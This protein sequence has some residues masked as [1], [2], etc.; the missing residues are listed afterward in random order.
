MIEID[1]PSYAEDFEITLD[2]F[3]DTRIR[4]HPRMDILFVLSGVL[5]ITT[6]R[7]KAV[8][9]TNH[10]CVVNSMEL[11][12]TFA[13]N[14]CYVVTFS[15]SSHL[16][17]N[18]KNRI[19]CMSGDK[20]IPDEIYHQ[21]RGKLARIFQLY[22][23]DAE[24]NRMQIY[25]RLFAM[26]DIL[27]KYFSVHDEGV[28]HADSSLSQMEQILTYIQENSGWK[29]TLNDLANQFYLSTG[30][31]SR[32][33]TRHLQTTFVDYLR[34]LR[35]TNAYRLLHDEEKSLA[36]IAME[37][38]FGSVNQ[39]IDGFK[40]Y[41]GAT[42]GKLR[43]L[44]YE[45]QPL[46]IDAQKEI[47]D[48]LLSYAEKEAEVVP[49]LSLDAH[50]V[51]RF[52]YR[53]ENTCEGK[54]YTPGFFK[55]I[56]VGFAKDILYAP[57]QKQLKLCQDELGF[58]YIRFH[59]IFDDDMMIYSEDEK[60]RPKYN[61]NYLD[62]VYDYVVSLGFKIFVEFSYYPSELAQ[63]EKPVYHRRSYI[64]GLPKSMKKWCDLVKATVRH[65]IDR[66]GLSTV[67]EWWFR[68]GEGINVYFRRMAFEEYME[69][70]SSTYR[71]VKEVDESLQFGGLNLDFGQL[72]VTDQQDLDKY[73]AGLAGHGC[74]PDFFSFQCF[75]NVYSPDYESS[76]ISALSHRTEPF[77]LSPDEDYMANNLK[78]I[79]KKLRA[80][81][82]KNRPVILDTWNATMW[83][84]DPRNDICFKAAFLFKNMLENA[85]TLQGFGYWVLSDMFEEVHAS[86]QLFHGG[87]GL[88][89]YNGIPKAGYYAFWLLKKL[90][91]Y[92]VQRGDGYYV[93]RKKDGSIQIAMYNYCHY[94][95]FSRQ[96]VFIE[97][98]K[99]N[100]YEMFKN[101]ISR[102]YHL[103]L[104]VTSRNY[105]A[106]RYSVS[107]SKGGSSYEVW[108]DMGS[109]RT[110]EPEQAEYLRQRSL[111][112]YHT[113]FYQAENGVITVS[114]ELE[115]HEICVVILTPIFN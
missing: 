71:A 12:H 26:L 22:Y 68:A 32:L 105:R 93:T 49:G 55:L 74:H 39:M 43:K 92:F 69:L 87:Y 31:I 103:E 30:H 83:Q 42:P 25:S 51:E 88:L 21:I 75:H 56:N 2:D 101:E 77:A 52:Y 84:R 100:R 11:Y 23:K 4:N 109:P 38:G 111:P 24:N 41:Y 16:L 81:D 110:L 29:L 91:N 96:N 70:F 15:I 27:Q 97:G 73:L 112:S 57:I 115:A 36:D 80:Y 13:E 102:E 107:R 85:G 3:K 10:F 58:E 17:G 94:D 62:M 59:G 76:R 9:V 7:E 33:F 82:D 54:K 79:R 66:Y 65:C 19:N 98:D 64:R 48:H 18:L 44:T 35:T 8:V 46:E 114:E 78:K 47:L 53:V 86:S 95:T 1:K 108:R 45:K 67:R 104:S 6:V 40:R 60:G 28:L 89:T 63:D 50:P 20:R 90:G 99:D 113:D 5:R 34:E 72:Q 37:T 14:S 61:F 106:D